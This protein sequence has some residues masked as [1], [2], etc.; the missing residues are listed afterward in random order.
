M[1]ILGLKNARIFN[2]SIVQPLDYSITYNHNKATFFSYAQKMV[3]TVDES[4][5]L[6]LIAHPKPIISHRCGKKIKW[7]NDRA[8]VEPLPN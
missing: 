8:D 2:P 4:L 1:K 3:K 6:V 7:Q 5:K